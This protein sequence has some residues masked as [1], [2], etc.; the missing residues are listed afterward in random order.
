V[1]VVVALCGA[2]G[3]GFVAE[4]RAAAAAAAAG[5]DVECEFGEGAGEGE[6]PGTGQLAKPSQAQAPGFGGAFG[7]R[8]LG[9]D[10]GGVR[11]AAVLATVEMSLHD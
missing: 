4:W 3:E 8:R 9:W 10:H 11:E 2:E 7:G 1:P 5:E 6:C